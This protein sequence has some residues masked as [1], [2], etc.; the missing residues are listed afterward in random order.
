MQTISCYALLLNSLSDEDIEA[1]QENNVRFGMIYAPGSQIVL[2]PSEVAV[3]LLCFEKHLLD[4]FY[5]IEQLK[6]HTE[7]NLPPRQIH[8]NAYF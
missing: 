6:T 7:H 3:N 8:T 2:P 1:L 5:Q 4:K